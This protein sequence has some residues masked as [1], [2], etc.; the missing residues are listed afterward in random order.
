MSFVYTRQK[1][2]DASRWQEDLN[3]QE[4]WETKWQTK[5]HQETLQVIRI[6]LNRRFGRQSNY[7]LHGH[8]LEVVDSEKYLGVHLTNDPTWH[9]HEAATVDSWLLSECTMQVK[10]TVY[11]SLVISSIEYPSAVWGLSSLED[12]NK[13]EKV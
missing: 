2:D 1:D 7:M 9:K 4:E 3:A 11:T 10:H 5:F 8:I 6:N 13:L 12:I